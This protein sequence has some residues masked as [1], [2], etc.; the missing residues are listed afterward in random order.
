MA[1][2][3]GLVLPFG[4]ADMVAILR[5]QRNVILGVATLVLGLGMI[6]SFATTPQYR[7]TLAVRIAVSPGQ[8][9]DG[10]SVSN[11]DQN[12]LWHVDTFQKTQ[13]EILK[14]RSLRLQ[15]VDRYRQLGGTDL[16][17]GV[18][19]ADALGAILSATPR[20]TSEIVDI[21]VTHPDP[22]AATTL[23]NLI[24]DVYRES[25]LQA[26]RDGAREATAW[27]DRQ[28]E[29]YRQRIEK[30]TD[31]LHRYQQEHGI[32]DAGRD[33]TQLT[34]RADALYAKF[35]DTQTQRVALEAAVIAHRAMLSHGDL[36]ALVQDF[37]NPRLESLQRSLAEALAERATLSARYGE[38]HPALRNAEDRTNAIRAALA[39]EL[40]REVDAEST[41]MKALADAEKRLDSEISSARDAL[42][43]RKRLEDE[44]NRRV[45]QLEE[46]KRFYRG[47]VERGDALALAAQTQLSHVQIIDP[48]VEPRSP[49]LPRRT[50]DFLFWTG[51]GLFLGILV[52][53]IRE[54]VDDT[55]GSPLDVATWLR[56]PYL[57]IVPRLAGPNG[58]DDRALALYTFEQPDSNAAEAVRSI[59]TVLM[60]TPQAST[61]RRI[62]VT[63]SVA[64]EG[65]T[66]TTVR[67]GVAFASTGRR[68]VI[69]DADLRRPRVHRIFGED[70]KQGVTTAVGGDLEAALRHTPV[71]NLDYLAAGPD[72]EGPNELLVS[73]A[74]LAMLEALEARY[75]LILLDSPPSVLVSDAAILSKHV[76]GVVMVVRQHGPSRLLVR[77]AIQRLEQVGATVLGVVVNAVDLS[78]RSS[79]YKYY[80][81]YRYGYADR[82]KD[83]GK[84][85]EAPATRA[86]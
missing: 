37:N 25:N 73:S 57:G 15:V 14:S 41:H 52:G 31:E 79:S 7:A 49:V 76:D 48:A 60:M 33:V 22:K 82:Y 78:A 75:D 21:S 8:E 77:D 4:L 71:P 83:H 45:S 58:E 86:P 3:D 69:V 64:A 40:S 43:E 68:V 47:L 65:K 16:E 44:Y 85:K 56:V 72:V 46:Q 24:G 36:E 39:A 26:R 61:L 42:L 5:M 70:R 54:Y 67:L 38:K 11:D 59:R 53:L 10:G 74:M 50:Y 63:S 9:F 62:L 18:T 19:G 13:L 80:Y 20:S 66:S 6:R 1:E 30:A 35:A 27:L 2:S 17:E 12:Y 51:I 32:G 55:I 84:D 34:T 81:G 28:V 23:A 29:D